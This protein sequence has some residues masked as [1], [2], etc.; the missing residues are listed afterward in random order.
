M[1]IVV[2]AIRPWPLVV[3]IVV[4]AAVYVAAL[5][6]LRALNAEEWAIIR[7]AR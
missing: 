6:V 1:G 2:Y 3:V 5:V 4:G 7:G